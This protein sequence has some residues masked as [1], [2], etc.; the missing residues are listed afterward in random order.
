MT[1]C[2]WCGKEYDKNDED[3]FFSYGTYSYDSLKIDLCAE[4]AME[5]VDM[6]AD[7]VFEETCEECGVTFDP[8]E[9][10]CIS[11]DW[12]LAD[13]W[14]DSGEILCVNCAIKYEANK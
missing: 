12:Y 6:K 5:A 13:V 14:D 10:D 7:G 9:N 4:C 3:F 11:N 8:M 2:K 1:K